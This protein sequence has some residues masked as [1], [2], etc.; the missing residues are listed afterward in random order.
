MNVFQFLTYCVKEEH[1]SLDQL[2]DKLDDKLLATKIGDTETLA[3]RFT[4]IFEA[5]YHMVSYFDGQDDKSLSI[6][7]ASINT[8]R[9]ASKESMERHTGMLNSLTSD[10][11]FETWTSP[12][13]GKEFTKKWLLYHFLEHLSTHRGQIAHYINLHNLSK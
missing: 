5:E 13:S 10:I 12:R 3:D 9:A 7:D 4:H 8:L 6:N 2:L 1:K 11:L